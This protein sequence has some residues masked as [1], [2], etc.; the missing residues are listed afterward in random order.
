MRISFFIILLSV[1]VTPL[2]AKA[3]CKFTDGPNGTE[4][5]CSGTPL[6]P[7]EKEINEREQEKERR[8]VLEKEAKENEQ[9][10]AQAKVELEKRNSELDKAIKLSDLSVIALEKGSSYTKYSFKFTVSNPGR[11]GKILFDVKLYDGNEYEIDWFPMSAVFSAGE[12]RT[13]TH[14]FLVKGSFNRWRVEVINKL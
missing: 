3:E 2:T 7:E 10:E 5:V 4:V 14:T 6:T 1:L 8:L 13:L 11:T 12:T 9:R